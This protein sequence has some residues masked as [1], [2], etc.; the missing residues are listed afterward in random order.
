MDYRA[1]NPDA[2]RQAGA[3]LGRVLKDGD[4]VALVGDLGM[5]K[6][7]FSQG[8]GEG[9]GVAEAM[10]SPTF[11]IAFEYSSG[12]VPLYH[13]D[14]YRLDDPFELEDV[15]FYSLTDAATPGASLVEWADGFPDELPDDRLEVTIAAVP[16]KDAER[17]ITAVPTGPRAQRI[18]EAWQGQLSQNPA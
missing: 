6:T 1:E 17:H 14:L 12:R 11:N 7:L 4:F 15:D 3:A 13:F 5:G 2:T 10:T 9:A 16:G 18:L 8:V